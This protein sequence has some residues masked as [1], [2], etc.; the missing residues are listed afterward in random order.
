MRRRE[1]IATLCAAAVAWPHTAWTRQ[2]NQPITDTAEPLVSASWLRAR[3]DARPLTVLDIRSAAT[4]AAGHIPGAVHSDYETGWRTT[5]GG[6]A[7]MVPSTAELEVL[8]G[9]AGIAAD[10]RVVVVPA[11]RD[12]TEFGAAA[13][14]YWTLKLS[15]IRGVSILNGGFS[16]WRFTPDAAVESGSTETSPTLF[17]AT[18]DER[19]LANVHDVESIER[20]G[21][22]TLI[23]A[24]PYSFFAG[25]EKVPAVAAYG[26]IPGALSLDSAA[27]YDANTNRLRPRSELAKIAAIVPEG[28]IVTYCNSG[29]WSATDWFVL[30]ELLHRP[31]VKLY[32][33][34]MIEWTLDSRH[35]VEMAR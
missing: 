19:L 30:S 7:P 33:G 23:D 26:H 4:F 15:G 28:P 16:A 20:I 11:G 12:A 1:L 32:Y 35:R 34:S 24:R 21:G 3:L 22:A 6:T 2:N 10:S 9:E 31:D 13:R 27:F 18:I 17:T 5:P 14:V 25:K 29:H 8:I